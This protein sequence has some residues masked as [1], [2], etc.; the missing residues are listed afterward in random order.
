M[1]RI[2]YCIIL[3][4]FTATCL[5][6]VTA[7]EATEFSGSEA[8]NCTTLPCTNAGDIIFNLDA[9][10]IEMWKTPENNYLSVGENG[11]I[12]L[13]SLTS[14]GLELVWELEIDSNGNITCATYNS[15]YGLVAFGNETGTQIVDVGPNREKLQ[16]IFQGSPIIDIAWD[17]NDG[18]DTNQDGIIDIP[19]IW[20]ALQA[21]KK[22]VQYDLYVNLPNQKQTNE[23]ANEI[24]TVLILEDGSIITGGDDEIFIHNININD[25]M[26]L[27]DTLTPGYNGI[28][29][30]IMTNEAESKLYISENGGRKIISYDT[31]TWAATTVT[32]QGTNP[33]NLGFEEISGILLS[34]DNTFVLGTGN[35]LF[36]LDAETM[37][38]SD[39]EL[40]YPMGVD[41][42]ADTIYGGLIL[43]SDKN[44]HLLDFDQD[45]DNVPDTKDAFPY[46]PSQTV[47]LDGDGCGDDLQGSNPDSF[48]NDPFECIDS[49]QDGYG[50]NG[51]DFPNNIEE[52]K[53]SDDDGYG[54]NS[55]DFPEE[56]SQWI[57]SDDD[58]Y[59]DNL[60][61]QQPDDCPNQYGTSSV[62]RY[63]CPD[64][65]G[66][67]YSN[68]IEGEDNTNA[69][70]FPN[71]NTQFRD[72]DGDGFGDNPDG[73]GGDD[74]PVDFGT[75]NKTLE[76]SEEADLWLTP[77]YFGCK[78]A[79][80][81]GFADS[82]DQFDNDQ[83]E[84]L[85]AD[86][87]GVGS[88][89]D[90]DDKDA[91]FSTLEGKC[92]LQEQNNLS[93]DCIVTE[94][95]IK[96]EEELAQEKLQA[97]IKQAAIVGGIAFVIL[98][99]GILIVGQVFKAMNS[100]KRTKIKRDSTGNEEVMADESGKEFEYDS[101]F[102]EDS[103]WSDDPADELNV[104]LEAV[105]AAFDEDEVKTDP[106]AE[107]EGNITKE[108]VETIESP[109]V[110]ETPEQPSEVPPVPASGLP[111]GWTMDQWKWYGSE[112]LEKNK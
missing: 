49:D 25:Q 91:S 26:I 59:G 111:E 52:W 12:S 6:L 38:L 101:T 54:D 75:S 92:A 20:I 72:I 21:S 22:A 89:S 42:I 95:N 78:D 60:E 110:E 31:M 50:D 9:K 33:S 79:D 18:A 94:D 41:A 73:N 28:F 53:D 64:A 67:G 87:D 37:V 44:V 104:N 76:Y 1:R 17:P 70:L 80:F 69:D 81:D 16:F 2:G 58:G 46:D 43:I 35:N 99:I 40:A 96:S 47:D 83:Y 13:Y 10:P 103:A 23:H 19:H 65:D 32:G 45:N 90:Y 11:Y 62:D 93:K 77:S 85:D 68:P 84:W 105:D 7:L 24:G 66:D 29:D 63:G 30:I 109:E 100:S 108:E 71:D 86:N 82:T 102:S 39:D 14:E 74:C 3:L 88:N 56:E 4:L 98:I 57:D 112:W 51:D 48:P 107:N 27:T 15:E 97:S 5:P 36:F 55:D 34:M 8:N 106:L 61:G